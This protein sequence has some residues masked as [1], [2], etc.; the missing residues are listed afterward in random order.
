MAL[1]V[2][3]V[4]LEN[5]VAEFLFEASKFDRGLCTLLSTFALNLLN[6]GEGLDEA[7]VRNADGFHV[8]DAALGFPC[9]LDGSGLELFG[10][11]LEEIVGHVGNS[12]LCME[13]FLCV[14]HAKGDD[15]LGF[16]ERDGIGNGGLDALRQHI[17]IGLHEANL[18]AHLDGDH[19]G[20]LEVMDA[21]LKAVN[22]LC[23]VVCSLCICRIGGFLSLCEERREILLTQLLQLELACD[24][25]Q[26]QLM[27]IFLILGIEAIQHLRVRNQLLLVA[28]QGVDDFGD[29]DLDLIELGLHLGEV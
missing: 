24:D 2:L 3:A 20:Q 5:L 4:D 7:G 11:A 19:T 17:V 10:I 9:G 6:L 23:K 28:L 12:L 16:P 18:G 14:L 15:H 1:F 26:G 27:V 22:E 25:V 8:D 13:S 21:L 29:V